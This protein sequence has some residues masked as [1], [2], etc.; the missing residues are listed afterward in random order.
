M[1]I[2]LKD[3]LDAEDCLQDVEEYDISSG[4]NE[5]DEYLD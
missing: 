2:L 5:E 4:E 3:W 1:C